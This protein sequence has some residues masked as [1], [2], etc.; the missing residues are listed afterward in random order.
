[1]TDLLLQYATAAFAI[2]GFVNGVGFVF[3]K[4]WK[5]LVFFLVAI[6]TGT[7][8]GIMH[9]FSIP[10][11]EMGLLLGIASSGGYKVGQVIGGNT[12]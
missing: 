8:F 1:M 11:A 7:L 2:I 9:W 3:D 6:S 4:N 5:S 10:S 12:K